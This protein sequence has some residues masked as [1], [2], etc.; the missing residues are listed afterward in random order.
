MGV[1]Y[2]SARHVHGLRGVRRHPVSGPRLSGS[3]LT[4]SGTRGYPLQ[5][6]RSLECVV[7][8][9]PSCMCACLSVL[10]TMCSPCVYCAC[11]GVTSVAR[12]LRGSALMSCPAEECRALIWVFAL[13]QHLHGHHEISYFYL[14]MLADANLGATFAGSA[15]DPLYDPITPQ[16]R[17]QWRDVCRH[18]STSSRDSVFRNVAINPTYASRHVNSTFASPVVPIFHGTQSACIQMMYSPS[19]RRIRNH[20]GSEPSIGSRKRVWRNIDPA[21]VYSNPL[22]ATHARFPARIS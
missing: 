18:S 15:K 4:Q 7:S 14:P 9:R 11:G 8:M 6:V 3:R 13:A 2:I 19:R 21:D 12:L 17:T 16:I 10:A 5:G 20:S 1:Q 22:Y